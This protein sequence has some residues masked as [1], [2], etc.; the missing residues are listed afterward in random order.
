[1]YD[2]RGGSRKYL[3][4][5]LFTRSGFLARPSGSRCGE[6]LA[7]KNLGKNDRPG[8]SLL[9]VHFVHRSHIR[10]RSLRSRRP[11]LAAGEPL[12]RFAP[13]RMLL[14]PNWVI[15]WTNCSGW[16]GSLLHRATFLNAKREIATVHRFRF[17]L[18]D[19]LYCHNRPTHFGI[20]HLS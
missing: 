16:C 12:G 9:T 2:R 18:F 5:P 15:G 7:R 6:P 13:S 20:Y 3:P 11:S 14:H 8:R 10:R 17:I 1:M 19:T 4:K